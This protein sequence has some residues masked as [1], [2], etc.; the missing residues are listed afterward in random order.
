[1][2]RLKD[3]KKFINSIGVILIGLNVIYTIMIVF[4]DWTVKKE[5]VL[6]TLILTT[7]YVLYRLYLD[8]NKEDSFKK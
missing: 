5:I 6:P 1:M 7:I 3:L 4:L 8:K 2:W